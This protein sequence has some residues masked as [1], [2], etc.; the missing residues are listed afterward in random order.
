MAGQNRKPTGFFSCFLPSFVYFLNS[1]TPCTCPSSGERFYR[2][3]NPG[4]KETGV[5]VPSSLYGA[6]AQP[7]TSAHPDWIVAP[8]T[9]SATIR[10]PRAGHPTAVSCIVVRKLYAY[11]ICS[12]I[13]LI[14]RFPLLIRR[15]SNVTTP[16]PHLQ[17]ETGSNTDVILVA[18]PD[19]TVL[20]IHSCLHQK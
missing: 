14:L 6:N 12:A 9:W 15:P 10:T 1:T 11:T 7:T 4:M 2:L 3:V 16:S 18:P 17:D 8:S 19:V 20:A 5:V 13:W